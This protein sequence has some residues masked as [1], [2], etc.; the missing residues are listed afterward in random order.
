VTQQQS[1]GSKI[2]IIGAGSV[3]ATIAYAALIRGVAQRVALYDI[4]RTKLDAERLDLAHGSPFFPPASIEGSDDLEICK[5]AQVVVITAGAKQQPGQTRL[6]LAGA[7]ATMLRN[8]LPKLMKV[9]P[10]AILLL[11][12]NPVDVLTQ[13]TLQIT[14]LP[15]ERVFGSGTVLDSARF[16]FLIAERLK[17]AP[18]NVHAYIGGEHGDSSV[19]L[20]SSAIVGGVPLHAW[21]VQ[22]HGKLSVRDRVEIFT[23]VKDAAAQIIAG[24]GATNYAI[25]LA[26]AQILSSILDNANRIHPVSTYVSSFHDI[27]DVC[28]SLP[29]IVSARGAESP[30]EIPMNDAELAG[31]RASAETIR[32]TLKSVTS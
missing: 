15:R 25:G 8:L 18:Q 32:A 22:G 10:D 9:T 2:A 24:K 13:I 6:E 30:L 14:G 23:G 3:G 11:V 19:P 27:K 31:L 16:R 1:S 26:V 28:L 7:N 20:W 29:C 17:V 5:D 21:A 4:N 12:T